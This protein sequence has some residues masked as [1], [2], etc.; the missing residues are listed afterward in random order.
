[1]NIE[2]IFIICLLDSGEVTIACPLD[3]ED[4]PTPHSWVL[5]FSV[6]DNE[7]LHSTTG[8][9]TVILQDVKDNPTQCSQDIYM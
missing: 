9:F 4:A 6:Y 1:M 5:H 7:R 3:Y 8:T 2:Q